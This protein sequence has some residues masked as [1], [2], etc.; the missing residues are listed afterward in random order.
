VSR[1]AG[2]LVAVV[3][4]VL[5]LA[6]WAVLRIRFVRRASAAQRWLSRP[7]AREL[8]ALRALTRQRLDRLERLVGDPAGGFRHG[9]PAALDALAALE[10]RACGLAPRP[11]EG[12]PGAVSA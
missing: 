2:V 11:A 9:D 1:A 5:V 6:V 7:G 12:W 10:L 4:I 8:F 3:P